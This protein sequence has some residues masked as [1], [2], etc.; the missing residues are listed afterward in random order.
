M[1]HFNKIQID[2]GE[3]IKHNFTK[4]LRRPCQGRKFRKSLGESSN[5]INVEIYIVTLF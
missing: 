1:I 5:T 3:Y 2:D 4:G